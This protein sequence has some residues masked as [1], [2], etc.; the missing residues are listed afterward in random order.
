[1]QNPRPFF[2]RTGVS[3]TRR[4]TCA[5]FCKWSITFHVEFAARS[6]QTHEHEIYETDQGCIL[7]Y[8]MTGSVECV[9]VGSHIYT[10]STK[11]DLGGFFSFFFLLFLPKNC[12]LKLG[13]KPILMRTVSCGIYCVFLC[14]L[15]SSRSFFLRCPHPPTALL[16]LD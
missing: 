14:C 11:M 16:L 12:L 8:L 6:Q 1:M 4:G 2:T 7:L 10:P 15:P 3:D 13:T 9:S 5:E